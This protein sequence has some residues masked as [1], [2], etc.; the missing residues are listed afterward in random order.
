MN[1]SVR[2]FEPLASAPS[3]K[4]AMRQV[5]APVSVIT[6]GVENE[7]TGATVTTAQSL[8]VE[9]EVMQISLNLQSSTYLA[10]TR[11]NHFCVNLLAAHQRDIADRFSGR[12]GIQGAAR[13]EG[14][15]WSVLRSGTLA[16]DGALA[17]ID[18]EVEDIL[19]RHSH[20]LILG[21][22]LE[23]R[24]GKKQPALLYRDGDYGAIA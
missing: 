2:K 4:L 13:Y 20:G 8:S 17:N 5:A 21:R 1:A 16:L 7:L 11:N 9:P 23:I 14:G 15:A 19:V 24:L 12:E 3:L 10:I 6:A 22:V 18:C